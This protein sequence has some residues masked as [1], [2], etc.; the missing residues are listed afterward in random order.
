M[1][2]K[3]TVSFSREDFSIIG[4]KEE[5]VDNEE[6]ERRHRRLDREVAS[7]LGRSLAKELNN[8]GKDEVKNK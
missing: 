8:G 5:T 4:V 6:E 2:R 3:R 1:I 7:I